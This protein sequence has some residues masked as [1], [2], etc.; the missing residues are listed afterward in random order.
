[1]KSGTF[2]F[3]KQVHRDFLTCHLFGACLDF[4]LCVLFFVTAGLV[5]YM[6]AN[7]DNGKYIGLGLNGAERTTI[8]I[9]CRE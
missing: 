5:R 6:I 7:G 3:Y 8:M 1:M 2:S 9:D 4:I